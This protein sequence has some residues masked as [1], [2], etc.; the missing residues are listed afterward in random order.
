MALNPF[1]PRRHYWRIDGSATEVYSSERNALVPV[2]DA[3]FVAWKA[4]GGF[5]PSDI[6]SPDELADVL[7]P[8]GLLPDWL[9]DLAGDFIRP[10]P[11]TYSK[12][13]LKAYCAL[14]RWRKEVGG[15][16]VGAYNVPTDRETQAWLAGAYNYVVQ[17]PGS[18]VT[19]KTKTGN[20]VV[21]TEAQVIAVAK[22]VHQ[23]VQSCFAMEK[24]VDDQID[25]DTVTTL[26]QIDAAFEA[27]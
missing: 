19:F 17:N 16:T 5:T 7:K 1:N 9:R 8:Y 18:T 21:L 23:F 22:A 4:S 2:D 14:T 20:F 24:T 12:R 25:A 11:T 10:S 13:Q 26:A 6:K 3:E 15:T 27:L